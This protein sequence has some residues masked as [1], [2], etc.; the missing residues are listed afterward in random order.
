[1]S[2]MDS[3]WTLII[4]L[5]WCHFFCESNINQITVL[6]FLPPPPPLFHLYICFKGLGGG[7]GAGWHA[8]CEYLQISLSHTQLWST[9]P[10]KKKKK[11]TPE[12]IWVYETRLSTVYF[13]SATAIRL[14][15]KGYQHKSQPWRRKFSLCSFWE[16]NP[17]LSVTSSAS[18]LSHTSSLKVPKCRDLTKKPLPPPPG[19]SVTVSAQL[20][21]NTNS[22]VN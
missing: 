16:S 3:L 12:S 15:W 4:Y 21:L 14:G 9:T 19:H 22:E 8:I 20:H 6:S 1:M 5:D 17:D 18:P 7:G 11:T 13:Y 10:T 2:I